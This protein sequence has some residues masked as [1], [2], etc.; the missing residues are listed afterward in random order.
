M[1]LLRLSPTGLARSRFALSPLAETVGQLIAFQRT[2]TSSAYREW[3]ARDPVAAGLLG[4]VATTKWFP[5]FVGVPPTGGVDTALDGELAEVAAFSDDDVRRTLRDTVAASAARRDPDWLPSGDLAPRIAEVFEE[6][7]RRFV[8]PTWPRR[9]AVLE[10]EI[11]H[12]SGLLAAHGWQRA[13]T[14]M[15]RRSTWVGPDAIRFSDQRY[16]DRDI[17]DQ[18]L[19]FVPYTARQ[20]SWT[21]EHPPRYALVYP[22]RGAAAA[23]EPTPTDPLSVLLGPGRARVVAELARPA[24]STQLA[25]ALDLSLGTVSGHLAVLRDAG[26]VTRSRVGRG[27]FY[28]LT[29][30]GEALLGL[31]SV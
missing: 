7:W 25:A 9:R 26:V 23:L 1:T 28:R 3:T 16:S 8:L 21:C 31:P 29:E 15:T 18:G 6:G 4:L 30:R 20:G 2:G 11:T 19:L 27:V 17:G 12:R 13:V 5:D 22:A 14:G 10:R 24:T